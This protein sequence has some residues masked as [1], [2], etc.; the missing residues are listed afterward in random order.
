ML[1]QISISP[2]QALGIV[3]AEMEK[4]LR[5]RPRYKAEGGGGT[6]CV[7]VLC[8][9]RSLCLCVWHV[10]RVHIAELNGLVLPM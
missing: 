1:M 5:G 8:A 9:F 3:L 10:M 4:I 2:A 6:W 7:R